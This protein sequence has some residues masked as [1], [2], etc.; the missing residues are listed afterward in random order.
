MIICLFYALFTLVNCKKNDNLKNN[1]NDLQIL[2]NNDYS[3]PNKKNDI[4]NQEE[5]KFIAIS[6]LKSL[7]FKQFNN[8]AEFI[9]DEKGLHFSNVYLFN[10]DYDI[11]LNK[12][13][14]ISDL[15]DQSE[16]SWW[17]DSI[18]QMKGNISSYLETYFHCDLNLLETICINE[19][20]N[21]MIVTHYDDNGNNWEE[22][23]EGFRQA[24]LENILESFPKGIIV[25]CFF[26]PSGKYGGADWHSILLVFEKENDS[27]ILVG[28]ATDYMGM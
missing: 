6:V 16:F 9:S 28:I 13:E 22:L 1:Q 18:G 24:T 5:L 11:F 20:W 14:L 27:Y 19:I 8:L 4:I 26:N 25:D 23:H 12:S 7:I 17:D 3:Q 2:N 21:K 15:I 10:F